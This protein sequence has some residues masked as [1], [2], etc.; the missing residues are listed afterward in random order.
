M[1][2]TIQFWL[3]NLGSYPDFLPECP[4]VPG[5]NE[6]FKNKKDCSILMKKL[7]GF[8]KKSARIIWENFPEF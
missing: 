6:S 1:N 8:P 3:K 7:R 2:T 5:Q 4:P